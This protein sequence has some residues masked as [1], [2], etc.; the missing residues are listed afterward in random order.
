MAKKKETVSAKSLTQEMAAPTLTG[1]RN[2]W[3]ESV[4]GGLTPERLAQVLLGA[5]QNDINDFLTLAEEMEERDLHYHSV[6]STRKLAVGGLEAV[7]EAVTDDPKEEELADDLSRL[8]KSDLF[9]NL[10]ADQM[11]AIGKGFAVNEIIWDRSESIWY[12]KEFKQRDQRF[13]QFD[14]ETR[15]VLRLR[16]EA[17]MANG[18]ELPPYKFVQHLPRIK[19]GI[20]IRGGLARLAVVAFMCKGYALKDWLAFSE[21]FGMP[22]RLGK[23][24][25]GATPQQKAALL[26]AVSNIGT[27]A[28][29]IVPD[30]MAIEFIQTGTAS[31]G[32]KLFIGLADWLD[33]QVS[34]GVL[35]QTM[36]TD[37][38]SSLSQARV[39][40]SVRN[41]IM[42]SDAKQLAATIRRDVIKPYVDLN[43]G[44]RKE[45]EY[46]VFRFQVEEPEDL[47]M[48][49]RSLPPFIA[50]GL[51]VEA[52]VIR[53]KFGLPEPEEGAETLGA[54]AAPP[55]PFGGPPTPGAI[56]QGGPPAAPVDETPM[57]A[58]AAVVALLTS[59]LVNGE[60][61]TKD[62]RL[63]LGLAEQ[64]TDEVGIMVDEA[65]SHWD[66]EMKP[67][68]DPIL[69]LVKAASSYEEFLA[70]LSD[71]ELDSSKLSQAVAT[72]TFKARALGDKSV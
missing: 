43:Y 39:H 10:V 19:T 50:L 54:P 3:N 44:P 48:L 60:T 14:D 6:L 30:S 65:S 42:V 63:F 29:A 7:V 2:V 61:L 25:T 57:S 38:G 1:V 20:P 45:H 31:G 56:P 9:A 69:A 18:L 23:Y 53:D 55:S 35:G 34:K 70:G 36:T 22:L 52:S 13:F 71:L 62:Q 67:I 49:S 58:R 16:D 51:K 15:S 5:D 66:E 17:D 37:D 41:D 46:P 26:S 24:G 27:D 21:V 28:A 47:E 33:R 4:A 32:D 68:L 12:P 11:D 8:C 40:D 72:L 64:Q 59:K